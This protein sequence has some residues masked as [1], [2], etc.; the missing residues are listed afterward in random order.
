MRGP[1][2][3][4]ASI[5]PFQREQC[6]SVTCHVPNQRHTGGE[7]L[8]AFV[9]SQM[10]VHVRQARQQRPTPRVDSL[11]AGG[12]GYFSVGA[13]G[14]DAIAFDQH[15][16]AWGR[17]ARLRVEQVRI[18]DGERG[19]LSRQSADLLL[20]A[21]V[22]TGALQFLQFGNAGLPAFPNRHEPAADGGEE[23]AVLLQ[24]DDLRREAQAGDLVAGHA[25]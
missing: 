6:V 8:D 4:P 7:M 18:H 17:L 20:G 5:R 12:D 1:I 23:A 11:R 10:H 9:F 14:S 16:A 15:G 19:R 22:C 25:A 24:P 3:S 2:S 13:D 21:N